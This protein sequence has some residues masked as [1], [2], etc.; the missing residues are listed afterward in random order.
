MIGIG[1]RSS[2]IGAETYIV[3]SH[4]KSIPSREQKAQRPPNIEERERRIV[5][6]GKQKG[7]RCKIRGAAPYRVLQGLE[8]QAKRLVFYL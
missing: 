7:R 3:T 1:G 6:H 4:K 8:E 2:D 5:D